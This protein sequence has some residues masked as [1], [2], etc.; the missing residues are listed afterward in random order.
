MQSLASLSGLSIHVAMSYSVGHRCGL[1]PVL[2]WL[3]LWLWL[4]ALA[5]IPPLTWGP[6]YALGVALKS[7]N[8]NNI[9]NNNL[10]SSHRGAVV[11][12]SD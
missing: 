8:N 3:W 1:N 4:A 11:N 7:K 5:P 9:N 10:G 12:E 2:L 6:A